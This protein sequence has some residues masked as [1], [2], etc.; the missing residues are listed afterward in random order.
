MTIEGI[1]FLWKEMNQMLVLKRT[2]IFIVLVVAMLSGGC[3]L[4]PI[5]FTTIK[6]ITESPANFDGKEVKLKGKVKSVTKVALLDIKLYVLDDGTGQVTVIPADNLPGEN[7]TVAFSGVV[8][9]V[10]IV[11]GQSLGMHIKETRRLPVLNFGK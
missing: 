11:G 6:E 8:E 5:G 1:W 4:V 2:W 7:E 3:N 10:A 9:N